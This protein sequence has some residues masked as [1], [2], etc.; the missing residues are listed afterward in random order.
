MSNTSGLLHD[1]PLYKAVAE[2]G[3]NGPDPDFIP[4]AAIRATESLGIQTAGNP[5]QL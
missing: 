5:C 4:V 1:L 2:S 3:D